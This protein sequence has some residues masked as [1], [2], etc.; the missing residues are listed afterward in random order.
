[1]AHVSWTDIHEHLEPLRLPHQGIHKLGSPQNEDCNSWGQYGGLRYI[2]KLPS[3][4]VSSL[5]SEGLSASGP[6]LLRHH[7]GLLQTEGP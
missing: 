3:P 2:W 1:M 5:G 7:R 4:L 6:R